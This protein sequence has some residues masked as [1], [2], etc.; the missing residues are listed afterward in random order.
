LWTP[1]KAAD[2]GICQFGLH[3]DV[4]ARDA[5]IT[6]K[7]QSENGGFLRLIGLK[8]KKGMIISEKYDWRTI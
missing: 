8:T 5:G 6:R 7:S 4:S 3:E 2:A 1:L